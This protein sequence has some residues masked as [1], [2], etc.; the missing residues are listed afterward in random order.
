MSVAEVAIRKKG[1]LKNYPM[2]TEDNGILLTGSKLNSILR[3]A[4]PEFADGKKFLSTH[5]FRL[6]IPS[7]MARSGY[8]DAE[9]K[10][11]GR[12]T[13]DSYNAYVK[14]GRAQRWLNQWKL[15]CAMAC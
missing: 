10:I 9:I 15:S 7:E 1:A 12:W 14:L 2:F 3:E 6:G 8:S 11:Q 4:F 13:S 5:S